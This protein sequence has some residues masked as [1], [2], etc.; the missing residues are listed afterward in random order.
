MRLRATVIREPRIRTPEPPHPEGVAERRVSKDAAATVR[1][2]RGLA[3]RD[4]ALT[5]GSSAGG[6]KQRVP[7][8][9]SLGVPR[10]LLSRPPFLRRR[11]EHHAFE[12]HAVRVG[13]IDR[14]IGGLVVLTGRIDHGQAVLDQE[15]A[16]CVH[17]LAARKLECVMVKSDVTLAV[18]VLLA[19]GVGGG[20][21]EQGL[22]VAPTRHVRIFVLELEAEKAEHLAVE[23][24]RACEVADA[25]HEVIDADD[26]GH[27]LLLAV[28]P[29]LSDLLRA[30]QR[31]RGF[32][33]PRMPA[34]PEV[35][36]GPGR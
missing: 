6:E 27:A 21:P 2:A 32:Q 4:A 12:L 16:E 35:E 34:R 24:L 22:A 26:A 11:L 17:I 29:T 3:L 36:R 13:E 9:T 28:V 20:D 15:R 31:P 8:V 30:D 33:P 1:L 7:G 18:L 5:R 25:E 19:L 10:L 14:V 23:V